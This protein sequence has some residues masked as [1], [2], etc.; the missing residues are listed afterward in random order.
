M[1]CKSMER[2]HPAHDRVQE[3]FLI[4]TVNKN[5]MCF[6]KGGTFLGEMRNYK[7]SRETDP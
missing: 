1:N 5:E 7:L 3:R 2:V 6:I 4:D